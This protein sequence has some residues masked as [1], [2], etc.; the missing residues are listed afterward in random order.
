MPVLGV[1]LIG[2]MMAVASWGRNPMAKRAD[3]IF[4]V[5]FLGLGLFLHY[6]G[7]SHILNLNSVCWPALLL[8]VILADRVVRFVRLGKLP[9]AHLCLPAVV[10]ALV[11]FCC[12]PFARNIGKLWNDTVSNYVTRNTPSD[13]LI[14]DELA[15]IRAHSVRGEQ[16]LILAR[17]QG[18]Y[19]T[20]T[21]L[22]SPVTGPGYVEML[23]MR[24]LDA[25]LQQLL[26]KQYGCVFVGRGKDSA[27][28]LGIDLLAILLQRYSIEATSS[29]GSMLYLRPRT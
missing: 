25:L 23:T 11:L 2:M 18:L 27:L 3:L 4:F 9:C 29:K 8:A 22:V 28:E 12:L 1:Y 24:D 20:S 26:D 10:L 15:F 17:R 7:R 14:S 16:C 13:P 19:Y 6:Q 21:G 5:S